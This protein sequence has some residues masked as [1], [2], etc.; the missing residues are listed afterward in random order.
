VDGSIRSPW[1]REE[2]GGADD[3]ERCEIH[4]GA[5]TS[6]ITI[7]NKSSRY[8]SWVMLVSTCTAAAGT[9]R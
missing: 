1:R 5:S 2:N 8:L 4:E 7:I 9:C 6:R 3:D